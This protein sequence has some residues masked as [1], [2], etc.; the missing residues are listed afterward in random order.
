MNEENEVA[1]PAGWNGNAPPH[2]KHSF[3]LIIMRQ[4]Q[5][6]RFFSEHLENNVYLRRKWKENTPVQNQG[7][8]PPCDFSCYK[9]LRF[10][11]PFLSSPFWNMS[12]ERCKIHRLRLKVL[13]LE[14]SDWHQS[15]GDPQIGADDVTETREKGSEGPG[16]AGNLVGPKSMGSR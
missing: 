4:S 6:K 11:C 16:H 10:S 7:K 12:V 14:S 5:P 13:R 2:G 8:C 9:T 15:H 1:F 3:L